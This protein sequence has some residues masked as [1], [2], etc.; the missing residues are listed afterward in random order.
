MLLAVITGQKITLTFRFSIKP[1][2]LKTLPAAATKR[3]PQDKL[4]PMS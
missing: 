1:I 3:N 2:T 4:Y